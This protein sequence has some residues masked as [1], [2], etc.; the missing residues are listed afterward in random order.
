METSYTHIAFETV[1]AT[2]VP[3][4]K[5][6]FTV[7]YEQVIAMQVAGGETV[8]PADGTDYPEV[9][10]SSV[11]VPAAF[12]GRLIDYWA[13]RYCSPVP[14]SLGRNC[15]D[16]AL[17]MRGADMPR[18]HWEV[19]NSW[20]PTFRAA[21]ELYETGR[22][23][24]TD[25][26]TLSRLRLRAGAVALFASEAA[27]GTGNEADALLATNMVHALVATGEQAT[28]KA[29]LHVVVTKGA[30]AFTALVHSFDYLDRY[31]V[32]GMKEPA[33]PDIRLRV[34]E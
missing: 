33:F 12:G 20:C 1:L 19:D 27:R 8:R 4:G 3:D 30:L 17:H 11:L 5:P 2:A 21:E 25:P 18:P 10:R 34:V 29:W 26:E 15:L 13:S 32:P 24:A 22:E 16:F 7:P 9:Q 31:I 23:V 6:P 28:D 14:T